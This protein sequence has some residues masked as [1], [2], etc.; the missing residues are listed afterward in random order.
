MIEAVRA[1]LENH[2]TAVWFALLCEQGPDAIEQQAW[3]LQAEL[4]DRGI[5]AGL[6][7]VQD[8][9]LQ[10]AYELL[11]DSPAG[12]DPRDR[13]THDLGRWATGQPPEVQGRLRVLLEGPGSTGAFAGSLASLRAFLRKVC[14]EALEKEAA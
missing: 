11:P 10:L 1:E 4:K 5:K 9:M 8:A 14:T 3:Q 12:I 6:R 13:L 2:D 7:D